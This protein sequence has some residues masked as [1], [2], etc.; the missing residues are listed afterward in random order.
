MRLLWNEAGRNFAGLIFFGHR[1]GLVDQ[2]AVGL[3]RLQG[4]RTGDGHW[5]GQGSA[6]ADDAG[7]NE[8]LVSVRDWLA[9]RH[10][11]GARYGE[12]WWRLSVLR[13]QS[14]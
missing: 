1:F 14:A 5:S 9:H 12:S 10:R 2:I 6:D 11:N 3:Q 8:T 13:V 4:G 7:T